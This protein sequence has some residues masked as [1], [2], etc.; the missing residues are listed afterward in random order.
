M[1]VNMQPLKLSITWLLPPTPI[2]STREQFHILLMC[3]LLFHTCTHRKLCVYFCECVLCLGEDGK[4]L[5]KAYHVLCLISCELNGNFFW[6]NNGCFHE[7]CK[8]QNV[9]FLDIAW[10]ARIITKAKASKQTKAP[11][12]WSII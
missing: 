2:S 10:K 9:N 11:L 8:L 12:S 3:T 6:G 1:Q 7:K 4:L 5:W